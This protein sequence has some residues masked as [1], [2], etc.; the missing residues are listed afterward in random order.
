MST[1]SCSNPPQAIHC[2]KSSGRVKGRTVIMT[3]HY[4][5]ASAIWVTVRSGQRYKKPFLEKK[6][7]YQRT[8]RKCQIGNLYQVRFL[9]SDTS[10]CHPL[11]CCFH[12][13]TRE[14]E[15]KKC[16]VHFY[17]VVFMKVTGFAFLLNV[18]TWISI[19]KLNMSTF[20]SKS[21][22]QRKVRKLIRMKQ[23]F[24][25]FSVSSPYV[26]MRIWIP[27]NVH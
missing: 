24:A 11:R 8:E 23:T 9:H 2:Y 10:L 26:N 1:S 16:E 4:R 19:N 12:L 15:Q 27:Q 17:N 14:R 18:I 22:Y 5:S 25:A 13:W 21:L 3:R 20:I 6:K 7:S